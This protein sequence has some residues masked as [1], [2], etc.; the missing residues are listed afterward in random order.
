VLQLWLEKCG[1]S[2]VVA[3]REQAGPG[4]EGGR[5]FAQFSAGR[6]SIAHSCQIML[7]FLA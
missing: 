7:H 3:D 6:N 2:S 4:T 5:N 1:G